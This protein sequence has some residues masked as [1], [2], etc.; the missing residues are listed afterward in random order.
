MLLALIPSQ[1]VVRN[2][3]NWNIM[4]KCGT[5]VTVGYMVDSVKLKDLTD[6][7]LAHTIPQLHF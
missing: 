3:N 2:P 5:L 1:A 4:G 7:I 6:D